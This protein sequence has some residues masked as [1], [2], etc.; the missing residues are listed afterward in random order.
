[1]TI[2]P[3]H[4]LLPRPGGYGALGQPA[5]RGSRPAVVR[6]LPAVARLA[7]NSMSPVVLEPAFVATPVAGLVT[8][9]GL[10]T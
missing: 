2:L 5:E 8:R 1:M 9:P 10:V 6:G 4:P 3:F 7:I